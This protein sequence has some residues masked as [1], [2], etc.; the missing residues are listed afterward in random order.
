[1]ESQN[2]KK[3][4]PDPLSS[5]EENKEFEYHLNSPNSPTVSIELVEDWNSSLPL[6]TR[7]PNSWSQTQPVQK[8]NDKEDPDEIS[9]EGEDFTVE[10]ETTNGR[11]PWK[12]QVVFPNRERTP[13]KNDKSVVMKVNNREPHRFNSDVEEAPFL[14]GNPTK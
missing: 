2:S 7:K 14:D 11:K 3:D 5:D 13:S 6:V 4:S 9:A 10:V 8:S 12:P 1:M